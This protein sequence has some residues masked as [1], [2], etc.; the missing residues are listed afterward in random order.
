MLLKS[1]YGSRRSFSSSANDEGIE[2]VFSLAVCGSE[3]TDNDTVVAVFGEHIHCRLKE[4]D[5]GD[6]FPTNHNDM[7][8]QGVYLK[9]K[10]PCCSI[11]TLYSFQ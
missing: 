7:Q 10:C 5:V 11:T 8:Y 3:N 6:K 2:V 1:T 9:D 4:N